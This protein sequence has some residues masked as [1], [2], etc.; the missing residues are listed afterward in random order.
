[1]V[2][3]TLLALAVL[4]VLVLVPGVTRSW[5]ARR[6]ERLNLD[7][8]AGPE[9]EVE[10]GSTEGPG[11]VE[12]RLLGA[13]F[14]IGQFAF[15]AIVIVAGLI[16]F[17]LIIELVPRATW[18][19]LLGACIAAYLPWFIVTEIAVFRARRFE[20]K[21]VDT[22][23]LIVGALQ[24]G[25]VPDRALA[26]AA[27]LSD[28]PVRSELE[29]LVSRL[30]LGMA[31]ERATARIMTRYDCE[32]AQLFAQTLIAK[33]QTGGD[34]APVLISVN[35]ILRERLRL[36]LRLKGQLAGASL[37]AIMIA[38]L[39]YLLIPFFLWR[40]PRWVDHLVEHPMGPQLLFGAMLLQLLGFLWLRRIMK[41]RM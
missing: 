20:E 40:Q 28:E 39:P 27:D 8:V 38:I 5:I 16:G 33:W 31:I 17:L 32:G 34:L 41:V 6:Q 11:S 21:L 4:V 36:R 10:I 9:P 13:G 35:A 24:A 18:P 22:I 3:I 19:A 26:S 37:S 12:R 25:E 2:E 30:G 1:M 29:E 23:D 14:G 15:L 7:T